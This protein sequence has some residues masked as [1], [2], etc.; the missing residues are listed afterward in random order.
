MFFCEQNREYK[1]IESLYTQ[2]EVHLN[3]V[4]FVA[5]F[6]AYTKE[7]DSW[8]KFAAIPVA[9]ELVMMWAYK[10]NQVLD[11]KQ[12]VWNS[13]EK[14]KDTILEH[15]LI[16]SCIVKILE[17]QINLPETVR[18]QIFQFTRDLPV[19]FLIERNF[20]NN[21]YSSLETIKSQWKEKYIERN[22]KFNSL[23]DATPIIGY[24]LAS[25][26]DIYP[27]YLK[28]I[29][30]EWR[31]S[32][33]GQVINDLS[34]CLPE[35]DTK[36]KSYQDQCADI[37]NGII[38]YPVFELLDSPVVLRA[39]EQPTV[40]REPSWQDNFFKLVKEEMLDKKVKDMGESCYQ[41]HINFWTMSIGTSN[42]FLLA[43]YMLLRKN[44]YFKKFEQE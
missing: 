6:H 38:T 37:R 15:D 32:H 11:R 28:T 14:I 16:L 17:D 44:K 29:S 1:I 10:T 25:N 23:Y 9:I 22:I 41:K 33:I 31:F 43:T 36:V 42:E 34:D 27:S 2:K 12:E 21:N 30:T 24:T 7:F 26:N 40:T 19:G 39:L 3:G 8:K 35:H 4:Q 13:D 20:L 5:G 18:K